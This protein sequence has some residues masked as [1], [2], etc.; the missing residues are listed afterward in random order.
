MSGPGAPLSRSGP[1]RAALVVAG[2]LALYFFSLTI[3]DPDLWGHVRFGQDV[4]DAGAIVRPDPYSFLTG[5]Q[6]WINHEWLAEVAFASVYDAFG[7]PGLIALKTAVALLVL[8]LALRHVGGW[9][10]GQAV[11]LA[12]TAG[13]LL[14]WLANVR[15]QMF[16]YLGALLLLLILDGAERGRAGRI[17]W[18]PALF[19]VWVNLH[20]GVLAGAA[21]L[22]VWFVAR[23]LAGAGRS[24]RLA[25]GRRL[26]APVLVSIAA[27]LVN[28]YGIRLPVFLITAATAPRPDIAEWAPID[29]A[30]PYG[31]VWLAVMIVAAVALRSSRRSRPLASTLL[32]AGTALSPLLAVR[33][34]P[35][36]AI[37]FAV[38]AGPH[39]V[40]GWTRAIAARRVPPPPAA[41]RRMAPIAGAFAAA[42]FVA[43]ALPHFRCIHIRPN[44]VPAAAIALVRETQV[45]GALA[46][47]F[48]WGQYAIWHLGPRVRVSDDGRRETVYSPRARALNDRFTAGLGRWDD[49][50]AAGPVDVAL[51]STDVPAVNLMKRK[52]GWRLVREDV[53]WALF[54]RDGSPA[55]AELARAP[56]REARAPA[57]WPGGPRM[58]ARALAPRARAA[59]E[60]SCAGS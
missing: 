35:L 6:P 48:D 40:D 56:Q 60:R 39:V 5:D 23:A 18:T 57:C 3:A 28:P 45:R 20:G 44:D 43:L 34:A 51:V 55:M 53:R 37:A 2:A 52:P 30:S 25:I 24:D 31:V 7:A 12:A 22:A 32:L 9:G 16:T 21:L 54:A 59:T 17:W 42:A 15:P 38:V 8:G 49:L 47:Y 58:D 33:H 13:L 1:G 46:I 41:L 36:F 27:L 11:A 26:V 50:L 29:V 10:S 14:P 19:A 4:L